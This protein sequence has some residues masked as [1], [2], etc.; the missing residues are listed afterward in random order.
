[1]LQTFLGDIFSDLPEV[2]NFTISDRTSYESGPK[3]P[4]QQYLRRDPPEWA[5]GRYTRA[6]NAVHSM[7]STQEDMAF[8]LKSLT[9]L[10]H[11]AL[12]VDFCPL[13]PLHQVCCTVWQV[14]CIRNAAC[15]SML[16]L[17]STLLTSAHGCHL[18]RCSDGTCCSPTS[19]HDHRAC[20]F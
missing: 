3:T 10:P 7:A 15:S 19:L 6:E 2:S 16:L 4:M 18:S 8:R 20:G 13:R 17:Y 1:M 12:A 9:H 5:A 14:Q 11:P